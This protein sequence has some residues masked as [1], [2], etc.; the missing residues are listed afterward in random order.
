MKIT[1]TTSK[2]QKNNINDNTIIIDL[3]KCEDE[4]RKFYNL[5]N[6]ETLYMK[7]M[8]I[9]QVGMKIP[10]I[11]YDVY[12]KLYGENLI[13][14]KIS[15]CNESNIY[16]YMPANNNGNLDQLNKSSDYYNDICSTATSESK[17]DITHK[18]R[19]K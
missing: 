17:T 8:E 5:T 18:D 9:T 1:F 19:Q 11:E 3:G 10:K 13:K 14:L 4:L 6:N 2:N 7:K 12:C 16:L 15:I